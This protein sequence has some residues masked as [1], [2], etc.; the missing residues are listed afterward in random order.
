MPSNI[1]PGG[2]GNTPLPRMNISLED[3]LRHHI[4]D[5]FYVGF[6]AQGNQ[7]V[8]ADNQGICIWNRDTSGT[9]SLQRR[10]EQS[11]V[12]VAFS[13][14]TQKLACVGRDGNIYL[15]TNEGMLKATVEDQ[16]K[17]TSVAFF[18]HGNVLIAGNTACMIRILDYETL[19][20]LASFA[21]SLDKEC[22][23]LGLGCRDFCFAF[24]PDGTRVAM[25]CTS[26]E[27]R[28]QVWQIKQQQPFGIDYVG[29]IVGMEEGVCDLAYAPDGR[30]LAVATLMEETILLFDG[31][32]LQLLLVL[33]IPEEETIP[34]ALAFSPDGELIAAG[35]D[36][37]MVH[38]WKTKS[39]LLVQSFAAHT[40]GWNHQVSAIGDLDWA[41]SGQWIATS[42]QSPLATYDPIQKRYV[43]PDDFTVKIWS[44][45]KEDSRS[46]D[47]T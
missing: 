16:V 26:R 12:A 40:G 33:K 7:L 38:I 44:M 39:G 23:P 45:K 42:G 37:G 29:G 46:Q 10:I 30:L 1:Q 35:T 20:I 21:G 25:R 43:G 5:V 15:Y 19:M 31:Q 8:S 24:S 47:E 2:A 27:K 6:S 14:Q 3:T 22:D 11:C 32:T 13:S 28:V 34:Y 41:A 18:P 17:Y 4:S 9:W 36:N